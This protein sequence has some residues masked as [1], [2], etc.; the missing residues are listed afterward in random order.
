MANRQRSTDT[1]A[2]RVKANAIAVGASLTILAVLGGIFYSSYIAPRVEAQ[3]RD[4]AFSKLNGALLKK[5]VSGMGEQLD[6]IETQVDAL[7]AHLLRGQ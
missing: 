7:V 4:S 3:I 6:H 1:L 2:G 5:E